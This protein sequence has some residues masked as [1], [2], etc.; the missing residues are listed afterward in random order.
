M[1]TGAKQVSVFPPLTA[2]EG[3]FQ[4]K[5]LVKAWHRTRRVL[6]LGIEHGLAGLRHGIGLGTGLGP[7][8]D[9]ERGLNAVHT[10]VERALGLSLAGEHHKGELCTLF[11]AVRGDAVAYQS[12]HGR[13]GH[14]Q[15]PK[16]GGGAHGPT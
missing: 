11:H 14:Q 2:D 9:F 1:V 4:V 3:G 10:A 6:M 16:I 8:L 7:A 13:S 12:G 5:F 15:G